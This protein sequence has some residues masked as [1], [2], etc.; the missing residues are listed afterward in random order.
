M[1]HA[2]SF[3]VLLFFCFSATTSLQAQNTFPSTG[4]VGIGISPADYPLHVVTSTGSPAFFRSTS[5]GNSS[6]AFANATAQMNI[7]VGGTTPHPYIWSNSGS[8]FIGNDGGPAFF[9]KG[10]NNNSYV[11]INTTNPTWNLDV[12]GSIHTNN[13]LIADAQFA[14]SAAGWFRGTSTGDA[15]IIVQGGAGGWTPFWITATQ[16]VFRI[17]MSGAS[18]PSTGVI[19]IDNNGNMAVGGNTSTNYKLNVV[20][21]VRANQVTVNTTG[22]DFV[23]DTAYHLPSLRQ[24][25]SYILANHHLPDIASAKQMQDEG[26]NLGETQ[27]LLLKK[28]EELTLYIIDQNKK[29]AELQAQVDALKKKRK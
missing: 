6:I 13:I 29:M 20:G 17:G 15:N 26:V 19:N 7:G 5:S 4:N 21:S 16:N 25:E 9:I 24:V 3:V 1:K 18:E 2:L 10:M 23:F 14:N 28:V 8:F 22:A 12:N 27:T 11:G